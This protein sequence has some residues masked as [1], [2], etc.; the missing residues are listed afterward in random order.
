MR[1]KNDLLD[2]LLRFAVRIVILA[3]KLP[4]T[5]AGFAIA[6]QVVR[7]G[8]SVGANCQEAQDAS[9]GNDFL[10][11]LNISLREARETYY[12]LKVIQLSKLLPDIFVNSEMQEC[13][14]II[15]ILVKSVKTIKLK[16]GK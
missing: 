16:Y 1:D 5:P 4:K 11:K 9:S 6:S 7:S 13:N 14:E 3:G 15:S 12:W 8:T 2:R 10:Y